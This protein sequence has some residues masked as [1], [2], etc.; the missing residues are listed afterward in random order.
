[1]SEHGEQWTDIGT[2]RMPYILTARR[3][4]RDGQKQMLSLV[5]ANE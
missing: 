3:Y 1:M 2:H 4:S 5:F